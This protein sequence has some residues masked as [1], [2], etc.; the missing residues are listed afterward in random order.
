ML[1][2]VWLLLFVVATNEQTTES[3]IDVYDTQQ[4]CLI[5]R[6]ESIDP[7]DFRNEIFVCSYKENY[8]GK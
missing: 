3:V 6:K 1:S 7:M 5:A 4:E 8:N 2:N